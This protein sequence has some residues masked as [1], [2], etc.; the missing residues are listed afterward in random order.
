M[1]HDSFFA[2]Y[3][4]K[5]DFLIFYVLKLVPKTSKVNIVARC[6]LHVFPQLII[7]KGWKYKSTT[8]ESKISDLFYDNLAIYGKHENSANIRIL[9]LSPYISINAWNMQTVLNLNHKMLR[10]Y[11]FQCN[12]YLMTHDKR[13]RKCIY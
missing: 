7:H 1:C 9:A 2:L 11:F 13:K 8:R 4:E 12:N 10:K 5:K 6:T 3:T